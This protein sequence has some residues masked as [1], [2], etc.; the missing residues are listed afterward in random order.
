MEKENDETER[1]LKSPL[2][3]AAQVSLML[4]VSQ[5][6]VYRFA[7]RG[8]LKVCRIGSLVR[9]SLRDVNAYLASTYTGQA[10]D[11]PRANEPPH[12]LLTSEKPRQ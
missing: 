7:D 3:T 8:V 4:A 12:P 10:S 2:L 5:P 1:D 11:A 9:F 6:T